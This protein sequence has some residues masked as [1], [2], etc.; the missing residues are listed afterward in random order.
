MLRHKS[1][2]SLSLLHTDKIKPSNVPTASGAEIIYLDGMMA[3]FGPLASN[4]ITQ[5]STHVAN[6][7]ENYMTAEERIELFA[8]DYPDFRMASTAEIK[9]GFVLVRVELYKSWADPHPCASGLA[10]EN[11]KTQFA[12]EKAETSAYA[13]CITNTGDP[14]YSTMKDGSK[15]PRANRAEMEVV[16]N[17]QAL[18]WSVDPTDSAQPVGTHLELLKDQLGAT[19]MPEAPICA[20]GHMVFKSGKAK[21]TGKEWRG[22]MCTEKI[23]DKQCTPSWQKQTAAGD[24]YSPK[25]N[26]D[27]L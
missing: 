17:S 14:K 1:R 24:W 19:E 23:K 18:S 21:T 9:D 5:R 16:H 10:A 20:H 12:T 25:D 8:K 27:Y 15:A 4:L 13:R 22:F 11:L 7:L 2:P 3:L 26:S 6:F